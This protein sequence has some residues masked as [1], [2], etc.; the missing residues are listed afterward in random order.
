MMCNVSVVSVKGTQV[1]MI[2]RPTFDGSMGCPG[3][4]VGGEDNDCLAT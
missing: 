4:T 2:A 3:V 1:L